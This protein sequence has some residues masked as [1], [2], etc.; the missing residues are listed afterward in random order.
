MSEEN[1]RVLR[2]IG[3]TSGFNWDDVSAEQ[4]IDLVESQRRLNDAGA[5]NAQH[6]AE[7]AYRQMNAWLN[8][9]TARF[10]EKLFLTRRSLQEKP[11]YPNQT[12]RY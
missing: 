2:M 3:Q 4:F 10:K 8:D 12:K 5:A 7:Q 1:R 6:R 9:N 11:S